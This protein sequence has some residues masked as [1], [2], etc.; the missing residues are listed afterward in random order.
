MANSLTYIFDEIVLCN[1]DS[2]SASRMG[3]LAPRSNAIQAE[4][5]RRFRRSFII[6]V[7]VPKK[8]A[9]VTPSAI[10]CRKT[11]MIRYPPRIGCFGLETQMQRLF[12]F[13]RT[14]ARLE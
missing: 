12:S 4:L 14:F 9:V 11:G 6:P 8:R 3:R 2:P 5:G 1:L 7:G 10:R 13:T